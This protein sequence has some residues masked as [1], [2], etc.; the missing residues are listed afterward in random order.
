MKKRAGEGSHAEARR[1]EEEQTEGTEGNEENEE[2]LNTKTRRARSRREGGGSGRAAGR[3]AGAERSQG[4]P[5][6]KNSI[7]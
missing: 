2:E 1:R 6:Q 4:E 7:D 5:G 3:I